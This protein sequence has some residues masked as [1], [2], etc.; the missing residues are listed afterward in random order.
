M[1]RKFSLA[2]EP[3]NGAGKGASRRLRREGKVLGILYGGG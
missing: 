1:A 3:R 2:A